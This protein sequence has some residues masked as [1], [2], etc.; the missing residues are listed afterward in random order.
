[1]ILLPTQEGVSLCSSSWPETHVDYGGLKL[2]EIVPSL[3]LSQSARTEGT[4]HH[5]QVQSFKGRLPQICIIW[6]RK[7]FSGFMNQH[8]QKKGV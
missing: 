1:M 3:L 5:T 7:Q 4:C 2:T 6:G 8:K